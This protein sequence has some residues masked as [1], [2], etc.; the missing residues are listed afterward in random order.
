MLSAT[1]WRRKKEFIPFKTSPGCSPTNSQLECT[2]NIPMGSS[3][4]TSARTLGTS[5]ACAVSVLAILNNAAP[6]QTVPGDLT[7]VPRWAQQAIWYQVFVERF[8][9]GDTDNDPTPHDLEGAGPSAVPDGWRPMPWTHD[10]YQQADWEKRSGKDFYSTVQ[11]RRYGGDLRG[12]LESLDYLQDLGVTALYLNP[13]NDAPSLH[14]YDAR[15]YRHVDRNFGPCPRDDEMTMAA[16]NPTDPSTWQWTAA[17]KLFLE[18][19]QQLHRRGMRIIVDY[20]WNHTGRQFWAWQDIQRN[21]A[22]SRFA[23]W[24]EIDRFDDPETT[25]NEFAYRGWAGVRDLPEVRKLNAR[26]ETTPWG[27]VRRGDLPEEFKAHVFSVTRR[28][29]DPNGDGDPRDGVDGF[30]L[31]VAELVPIDF[32]REF[33]RFVRQINPE[34]FLVGEIWWEKWPDRLRDPRPWLTGDAFDAVMHYHWYVPTRSFFAQAPPHLEATQYAR[35]LKQLGEGIRPEVQRAMMNLVASHDSPRIATSLANPGRYK[36]HVGARNNRD[37]LSGKP[38]ETTRQIQRMVLVQQFTWPGAPHIFYGDEVG[39]WGADDPDCRKP[40]LWPELK[41][42]DERVH[43][44]GQRN[45]P[46]TVAPDQ[47]LRDFYRRLIAIRREHTDLFVDGSTRFLITDDAQG[48]LVY[49]RSLGQQSA[50]VFFNRSDEGRTVALELPPG[51]YH[52]ALEPDS[53]YEVRREPLSVELPPRQARLLM[54]KQH[55]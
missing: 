16:E 2:M 34:A 31:D 50:L 35:E 38:T 11:M 30:R 54:N 4:Q 7:R 43:P 8:R 45:P 47:S 1:Y 23:A 49:E 13:I 46:E 6:A 40:M 19:V 17:D 44:H 37:Y 5:L 39:M 27:Q 9:N 55:F 32:W 14:K 10:W 29:L 12:V 3:F 26:H 18:L 42:D 15:N 21:Q 20:S 36:Y 41:Y 53:H 25:Q 22:Q 28:W 48:V 52:D 24:Y 51:E 33:R